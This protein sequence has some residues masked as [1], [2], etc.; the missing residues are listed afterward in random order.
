MLS[1]QFA[2]ASPWILLP[3]VILAGCWTSAPRHRESRDSPATGTSVD[4]TD[5]PA[6]A[7]TTGHGTQLTGVPV[8]HSVWAPRCG[9][10]ENVV[11]LLRLSD[12]STATLHHPTL[13]LRATEARY[14]LGRLAQFNVRAPRWANQH[15]FEVLQSPLPVS[16][17]GD[18][19]R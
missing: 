11:T 5:L 9:H 1:H 14:P 7:A 15:H 2:Q 10:E 19:F 8:A 13:D 3:A 18:D 17:T 12:S 6:S 4:V 16:V